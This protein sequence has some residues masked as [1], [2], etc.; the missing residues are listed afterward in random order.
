MALTDTDIGNMAL[1]RI[2]Y[3]SEQ[4]SSLAEDSA[5]AQEVA[6]WYEKKRD[7]LLEMC[8]W[9]IMK[10]WDELVLVEENP[11]LDYAYSYRYPTDCV[12]GRDILIGSVDSRIYGP[13]NPVPY[14]TGM[15]DQGLLIY[16]DQE[17]ACLKYTARRTNTAYWPMAFGSALAWFLAI[18]LV[19]PLSRDVSIKV[20][21]KAE[22]EDALK[23]AQANSYNEETDD[24]EIDATGIANRSGASSH[25]YDSYWWR[26]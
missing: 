9:E 25:P 24:P 6:F 3:S 15:D 2:G 14:T 18:E 17:D 4:I 10:K 22:F 23:Q 16:T 26:R 12:F 7:E 5:E 1:A 20:N 21:A 11:N 19:I 8:P 13:Q